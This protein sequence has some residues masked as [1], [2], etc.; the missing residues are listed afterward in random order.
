M[1]NPNNGMSGSEVNGGGST[2]NYAN[3]KAVAVTAKG[4]N[5]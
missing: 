5:L 1:T 4:G 2:Q 3:Y